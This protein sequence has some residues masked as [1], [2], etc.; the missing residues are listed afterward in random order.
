[1]SRFET[2]HKTPSGET[3]V[4]IP[5]LVE[6]VKTGRRGQP[7]KSIDRN[8]LSEAILSARHIPFTELAKVLGVHWNTLHLHMK[9]YGIERKYS[10]LSTAALDSLIVQFKKQR[11]ESGIRYIIGFLRRQGVC[12]QYHR[13]V[14]S[15][16]RVDRVGQV[17]RN[18]QVK[19]RRKYYVKQPNALWHIDRHHKL[20]RWG[21][22]IHRVI[23]GFCRTVHI[24]LCTYSFG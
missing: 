10:A 2:N 22:V 6:V 21:I 1:M 13:V 11:P 9:H 8:Y 17:L 4:D 5:Q 12:V 19:H 18:R 24:L 23:D 3:N 14:Q 20:I 7:R 16:R 15:L